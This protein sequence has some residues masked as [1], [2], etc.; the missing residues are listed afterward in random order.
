MSSPL[1]N[2]EAVRAAAQE[3]GKIF[4]NRTYAIVGAAACVVLGSTRMTNDIDIVVPKGETLEVR[5]L[6]RN[7]EGFVVEKG[8]LHTYFQSNPRVQIKLL[9]PPL[10]YM[11]DFDAS[12]PTVLIGSARVL[13][14]ALLLNTIFHFILEKEEEEMRRD[15]L[16]IRFLLRW[17]HEHGYPPRAAECPRVTREL[18]GLYIQIFGGGA[19]WKNVGFDSETWWKG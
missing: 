13:M 5:R 3:I 12:T 16:D 6:F 1:S 7:Q 17:C 4:Q 18:V 19:D 11:E 10:L 9:T 15:A 2:P 8:T 14:P